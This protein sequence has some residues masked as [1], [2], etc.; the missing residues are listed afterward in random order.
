MKKIFSDSVLSFLKSHICLI[1]CFA[2]GCLAGFLGIA[3][4][5]AAGI[6]LEKILIHFGEE[7]NLRKALEE[8]RFENIKGEPFSGALY[9]CALAVFCLKDIENAVYQLRA[10]FGTDTDWYIYCRAAWGCEGMNGD[11]LVECLSSAIKKAKQQNCSEIPLP[12]IFRLLGSAEFLWDENE[13][14]TKPSRYLAELLDYQYVT[15]EIA[16]AYRVLGLNPGD[17]LEKVK[18]AH[19]KLAAKFHPDANGGSDS[20]NSLS[21]FVRIQTAYEAIVLQLS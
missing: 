18:A 2:I 20:E 10:V 7:K 21:S 14:G 3:G 17:S 12:D 4:G 1:I 11:L 9:V 16:D 5:L 6:I 8:G 19:R 15:D 13:R